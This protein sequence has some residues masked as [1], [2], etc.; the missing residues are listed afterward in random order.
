MLIRQMLVSFVLLVP[1]AGNAQTCKPESIQP[2]TG[3]LVDNKDGTIRD[4]KTGLE[5]K[6]CSEGQ[7]WNSVTNGCDG[8]AR[9]YRWKAALDW[10]QNVNGGMAGESLGRNDWRVPNIKELVSIVEDQ[11][12]YPAVNL[13]VFPSTPSSL[14]WSSS[15]VASLAGGARG[16]SFDYGYA[17][18]GFKDSAFQVRLVRSGQ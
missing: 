6:R 17:G 1:L 13:G 9:G 15:P 10:V 18:G 4:P 16:V 14:F 3:H 5:W 7:V 8:I 12:F 11:C 2:T